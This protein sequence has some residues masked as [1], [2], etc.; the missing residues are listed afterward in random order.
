MQQVLKMCYVPFLDESM[1][2]ILINALQKVRIFN[3]KTNSLCII[4]SCFLSKLKQALS[5]KNVFS[6]VGFITCTL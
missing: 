2:C 4:F 6:V 5:T 3:L 1:K